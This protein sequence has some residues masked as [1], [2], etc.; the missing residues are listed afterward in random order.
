MSFSNAGK[1]EQ[2]VDCDKTFGALS[3]DLSKA[4]DS[5][6]HELIIAK[7]NTYEFNLLALKLIH[8]YLLNRKQRTKVNSSYSDQLFIY[9]GVPRGSILGPLL[10]NI[11]SACFSSLMQLV[12]L[13]TLTKTLHT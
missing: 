4:Y 1:V 6:D 13:V 5:V 10:F 8:D 11:F 3:T 12:L 9:F 7:L 2:S